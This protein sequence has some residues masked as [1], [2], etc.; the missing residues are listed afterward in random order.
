MGEP[1][2]DKRFIALNG[3]KKVNEIH[4]DLGDHHEGP[5]DYVKR[6]PFYYY[7]HGDA[8]VHPYEEDP[9]ANQPKGYF[10]WDDPLEQRASFNQSWLVG[11]F[12]FTI[13][14]SY[15]MFAGHTK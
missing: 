15:A 11:L 13:F 2:G 9:C 1:N 10:V 6:D 8:Y 3:C 7:M 4:Y 5:Y 12:F 14:F